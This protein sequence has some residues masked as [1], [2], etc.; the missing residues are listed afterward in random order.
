MANQKMSLVKPLVEHVLESSDISLWRGAL[1]DQGIMSL[2]ETLALDE[3]AAKAAFKTMK[4]MQYMTVSIESVLEEIEKQ[5]LTWS[6]DL[7][8]EYQQGAI[9]Y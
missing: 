1:A 7:P 9:C 3:A 6:V 5:Q 2:E 8:V 4:I